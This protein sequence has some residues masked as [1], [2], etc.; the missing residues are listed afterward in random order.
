MLFQKG[1]Y[2]QGKRGVLVWGSCCCFFLFFWFLLLCFSSHLPSSVFVGFL[3]EEHGKCAWV[4]ADHLCND[5]SVFGYDVLEDE[6]LVHVDLAADGLV[7]EDVDFCL[8]VPP[9]VSLTTQTDPSRTDPTSK[10]WFI[11]E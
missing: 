7:A 5:I 10:T 1:L 8:T 9:A 3:N 2:G 6:H 4:G 11:R